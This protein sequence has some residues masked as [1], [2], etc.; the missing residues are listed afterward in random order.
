[1]DVERG[2]RCGA[3]VTEDT[4]AHGSLPDILEASDSGY[5]TVQMGVAGEMYFG[6]PVEVLATP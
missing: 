3:S 5:R 4:K 2:L 1:M 6:E